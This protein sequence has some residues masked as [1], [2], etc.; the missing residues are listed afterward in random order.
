MEEE[1][2][3]GGNLTFNKMSIR[4]DGLSQLLSS[5]GSD[6][7][8]NSNNE[9]EDSD[10]SENKIKSVRCNGNPRTESGDDGFEDLSKIQR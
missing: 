5:Y 2:Q 6:E 3:N 9:E 7:S 1:F 4:Q 10:R 8:E